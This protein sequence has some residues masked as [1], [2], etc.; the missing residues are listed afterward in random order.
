MQNSADLSA[1]SDSDMNDEIE[2]NRYS[3]SPL[4]IE[5]PDF[6]NDLDSNNFNFLNREKTPPPYS[7]PIALNIYLMNQK[8]FYLIFLPGKVY[9]KNV[10]RILLTQYF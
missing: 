3:N 9:Q 5:V 8:P 10:S 6:I 1:L 2:M 4:P 7:N